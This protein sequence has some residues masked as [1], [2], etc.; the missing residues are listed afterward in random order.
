MNPCAVLVEKRQM[1]VVGQS[2]D[3]EDTVP[4]LFRPRRHCTLVLV[5][6]RRTGHALGLRKVIVGLG[7]CLCHSVLL[8]DFARS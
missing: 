8:P 1:Q 6:S 4:S 2:S 7:H 5:Q 3:L